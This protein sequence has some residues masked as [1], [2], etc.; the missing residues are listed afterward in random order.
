MRRVG[1]ATMTTGVARLPRLDYELPA[2]RA[3]K[4]PGPVWTKRDAAP[5]SLI[6]RAIAAYNVDDGVLPLGDDQ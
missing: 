4:R 2:S 3:A 6:S 1:D 5:L